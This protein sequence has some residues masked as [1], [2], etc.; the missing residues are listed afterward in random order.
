MFV[1][2]RKSD[3]RDAENREAFVGESYN[4]HFAEWEGCDY[5]WCKSGELECLQERLTEQ[6][7]VA[8]FELFGNINALEKDVQVIFRDSVLGCG[9]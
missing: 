9:G 5:F 4:G 2:V 6:V 1:A 3:W 7:R 8:R